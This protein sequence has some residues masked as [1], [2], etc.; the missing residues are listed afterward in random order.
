M[1]RRIRESEQPQVPIPEEERTL[2][3]CINIKTCGFL[4]VEDE[5]EI[6]QSFLQR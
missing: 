6:S 4:L 3:E 5:V 1:G 2:H